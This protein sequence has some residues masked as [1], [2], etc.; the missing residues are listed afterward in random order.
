MLKQ[1][2]WAFGTNR[3]R[4]ALRLPTKTKANSRNHYAIAVG[5]QRSPLGMV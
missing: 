1:E 5:L 3:S 2:N 4:D